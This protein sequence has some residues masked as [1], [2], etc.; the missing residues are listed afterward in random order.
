MPS[1]ASDVPQFQVYPYKTGIRP[2]QMQLKRLN[3]IAVFCIVTGGKNKTERRFLQLFVENRCRLGERSFRSVKN[4]IISTIDL[5][6]FQR[7]AGHFHNTHTADHIVEKHIFLWIGMVKYVKNCIIKFKQISF[8][9]SIFLEILLI[10]YFAEIC[11]WYRFVKIISLNHLAFHTFEVIPFF[12]RLHA[13]GNDREF[14]PF[15]HA[16]DCFQND[17]SLFIA[18]Q[19]IHK[20][21]INL[22][23]VDRK[24]FQN[25]QRRIAASK[26][27]H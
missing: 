19:I 12:A 27:I 18:I 11:L 8:F 1:A 14:H 13:F 6:D 24:I 17:R 5:Q 22:Q 4:F 7:V 2:L 20:L 21:H 23:N 10:K 26:I 3:L 15:R 9:Y 25:V 16:D